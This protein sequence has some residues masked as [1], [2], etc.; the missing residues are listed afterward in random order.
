MKQIKLDKYVPN[1]KQSRLDNWI[2]KQM[3]LD[4][5]ILEKQDDNNDNNYINSLYKKESLYEDPMYSEK[6]LKILGNMITVEIGEDGSEIITPKNIY[7]KRILEEL[8][9]NR[10]DYK[11]ILTSAL[12]YAKRKGE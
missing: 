1:R 6:V 9:N 5:W 4:E 8:K 2:Y 10:S 3:T 7:A 12:R 11:S